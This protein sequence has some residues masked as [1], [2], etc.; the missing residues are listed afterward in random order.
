VVVFENKGSGSKGGTYL[1]C[2]GAKRKRKCP[3][4][5]WRYQDFEA[6]FLAFVEELDIESIANETTHRDELGKLE[7]ALAALNGELLSVTDLMEKAY[8]ILALGG[9]V[10]FVS[11]KLNELEARRTSLI[12]QIGQRSVERQEIVSRAE[13]YRGSKEEVRQLVARLQGLAGDDIFALR[14]RVASQLKSIVVELK[15]ASSGYRPTRVP[16]P[17]DREKY[18]VDLFKRQANPPDG[19]YMSV[20]FRDGGTRIIYPKSRDPLEPASEII[21]RRQSTNSSESADV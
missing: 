1:I 15:I 12:E 19:R 2:D 17:D 4:V 6:S 11:G 3:S 8:A 5:R 20:R 18:Y 9:A 10:A 13:R 14:A 7:S 21:V 16:D